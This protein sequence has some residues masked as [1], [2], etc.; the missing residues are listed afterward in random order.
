ML[1]KI[2]RGILMNEW[3]WLK[4]YQIWKSFALYTHLYNSLLTLIYNLFSFFLFISHVCVRM[5]SCV[6]VRMCIRVLLPRTDLNYVPQFGFVMFSFLFKFQ[7]NHFWFLS[8]K[9]RIGSFLSFVSWCGRFA[10]ILLI[11]F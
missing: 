2:S 7:N 6:C 9:W 4:N 10:C 3:K 1:M 11:M 5:R 8:I